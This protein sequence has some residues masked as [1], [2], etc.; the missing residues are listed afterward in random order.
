MKICSIRESFICSLQIFN[1]LKTEFHLN[2]V[3]FTYYVQLS[4]KKV[5][6][7]KNK[8]LFSISFTE[9]ICAG[10]LFSL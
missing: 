10:Q 7:E 9:L 5:T 4:S 2:L 3:Q 6:S 1:I 8:H